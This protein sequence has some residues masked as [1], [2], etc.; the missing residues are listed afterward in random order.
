LTNYLVKRKKL[1]EFAAH[2]ERLWGFGFVKMQRLRK[3]ESAGK[4]VLKAVGYTVK[5]GDGAQGTIYGNRY[6]ISKSIR[7]QSD[8]FDIYD[9]AEAR[10]GLERL[11]DDMESDIEPLEVSELPGVAPGP[12]L[13]VRCVRCGIVGVLIVSALTTVRTMVAADRIEHTVS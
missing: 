4:Y 6:G 12:L 8:T 10:E 7:V 13:C 1:E 2:V 5:G 9:Q 11:Q 3:P